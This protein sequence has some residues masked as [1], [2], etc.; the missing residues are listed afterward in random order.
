MN[1][2]NVSR[3]LILGG[4]GFIGQHLTQAC[5]SAGMTVR[6]ADMFLPA[7]EVRQDGVEYVEGD[8]KDP[9]FLES[10]LEEIDSIVHL[11]HDTMILNQECSMDVEFERN[12][13]PAMQ[14][15]D[16][17][18]S[19][20]IGKFLFVSSGGTVY[21]NQ[22]SRQPIAESSSTKPISLYGTSKLIIE[23]IGFLYNV[24]KNLPFIVA[25]PGNAYGPGQKPFRG[26][27]FVATAFAS[28]LKG[29]VLNIFGDGSVVRDYIHARDLADALVAILRFGK[30]GE[31]Y[32]IGTSNG[33]A[34][35][36][37]LN[38]YITPI[39]E[40]DG[41]SLQCQYTPPRGVDVPYNVLSNDKLRRD[42]NFSPSIELRDGLRETL[43]WLKNFK[44]M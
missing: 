20:K 23:N 41:Y 11:V 15:M 7:S 35:H 25:R 2:P 18:C 4:M 39:L 32:N 29:E 12:V 31:A 16:M 22:L 14:L 36:T 28:A 10:I 34:L 21:G 42:T 17:C 9:G 24:Q 44:L 38:E 30:L 3:V 27:G 40:D 37:L 43:M 13:R 6:V 19:K 33:V 1:A 5:R 26:Q 8:Y